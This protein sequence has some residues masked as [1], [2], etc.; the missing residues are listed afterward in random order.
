MEDRGGV[1]WSSRVSQ[2]MLVRQDRLQEGSELAIRKDR[3]RPDTDHKVQA[4]S[5]P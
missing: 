5:E 1:S 3:F 2:V 4:I